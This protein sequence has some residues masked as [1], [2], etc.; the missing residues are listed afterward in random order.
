V[1][2]ADDRFG[3]PSRSVLPGVEGD[4]QLVEVRADGGAEFGAILADAGGE[5]DGVRA[6]ELHEVIANPAARLADKDVQGEPGL[7]VAFGRGIGNIS[8]VVRQAGAETFQTG[9]LREL[10]LRLLEG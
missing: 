9:F 5:D 4:A 8:N 7:D 1:G 10:A 6:V 3:G 2:G